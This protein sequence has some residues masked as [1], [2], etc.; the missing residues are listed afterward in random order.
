[1]SWV[2][3]SW[4]ALKTLLK[5]KLSKKY[6]L[7]AFNF[8][9]F[10][11][12]SW[13]VPL[14]WKALRTLLKKY[15]TLF[16][17]IAKNLWRNLDGL[18]SCEKYSR[19]VLEEKFWKHKNS[20]FLFTKICDEIFMDS[21]GELSSRILEAKFLK[22]KLFHFRGEFSRHCWKENFRKNKISLL[23][24]SSKLSRGLDGFHSYGELS[25]PCWN[26]NFT[27]NSKYYFL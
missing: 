18:N 7:L 19:T 5:A 24:I 10:I 22:S 12:R 25:G 9:K 27:Q 2:P 15:K 14:L 11:A 13:W 6:N 1:M 16:S 20:V 23:L 8:L 4:R 26:R 3:L 21:S 17:L